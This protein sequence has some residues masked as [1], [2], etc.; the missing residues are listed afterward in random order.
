MI[1]SLHILLVNSIVGGFS[2][3]LWFMKLIVAPWQQP[4]C[5]GQKDTDEP[6]SALC[7]YMHIICTARLNAVNPW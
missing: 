2:H 1:K 6:T 4:I 3:F 5:D 7:F